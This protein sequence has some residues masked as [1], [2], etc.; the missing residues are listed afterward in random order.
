MPV[1][2]D[3]LGGFNAHRA[4]IGW[5]GLVELS[6]LAADGRRVLNQENLVTG[7][8]QIE[9]GLNAAD[10]S[11]DDHDVPKIAFGRTAC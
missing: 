11:A 9:G 8:G 6:H 3:E 2:F 10:P 7:I 5:K 1:T 4:V